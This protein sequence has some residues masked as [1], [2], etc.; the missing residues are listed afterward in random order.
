MRLPLIV[1]SDF[2]EPWPVYFRWVMVSEKIACEREDW[3][4]IAVDP[5]CRT[6]EPEERFCI[7]SKA[8]RTA[9][10]RRPD[11]MMCPALSSRIVTGVR[12]EG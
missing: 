4:F 10:S 5:V 7:T 1:M 12:S 2:G 11:Q 8:E 3:S 6:L 9:L